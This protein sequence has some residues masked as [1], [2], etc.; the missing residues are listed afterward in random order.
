MGKEEG[1]E[2]KMYRIPIFG[3]SELQNRF[4]RRGGRCRRKGQLGEERKGGS[5]TKTAA[6]AYYE[7]LWGVGGHRF[8]YLSKKKKKTERGRRDGCRGGET[9]LVGTIWVLIGA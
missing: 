3:G 9:E 2:S 8:L 6:A 5:G 1:E 4:S 7:K